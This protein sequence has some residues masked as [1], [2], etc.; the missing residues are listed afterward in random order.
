MI[1]RLEA[2]LRPVADLAKRDAVLLGLAVRSLGRWQVGQRGEQLISLLAELRQLRLELL[3]LGLARARC[4]A[5]FL[6]SRVV[7]LARPSGLLDLAGE[8]VLVRPDLIDA[9]VQLAPALVGGEELVELLG[10]TSPR[11]RRARRLGIVADL[12]EVERGSAPL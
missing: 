12:L 3:Q 1:E 7:G 5:R 9:R 4:L 6:E 2:E 11:Q 10:R 8:L